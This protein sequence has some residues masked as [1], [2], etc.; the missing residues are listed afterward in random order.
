KERGYLLRARYQP[1]WQASWVKS[2]TSFGLAE[3]SPVLWMRI[4][5]N[6]HVMFKMSD[7]NEYPDEAPILEFLS[8]KTLAGD[9]CN[10]CVPIYEILCIPDLNVIVIMVMPVLYD[11]QCPKFDTIGETVDASGRFSRHVALRR[12]SVPEFPVCS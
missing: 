11:L 6:A 9:P 8:S 10:H 12:C 4:S 3:D 1:G 7:I 5:D 2:G